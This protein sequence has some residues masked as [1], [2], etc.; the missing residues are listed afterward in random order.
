MN[1]EYITYTFIWPSYRLKNF[2]RDLGVLEVQSLFSNE[3]SSHR[4]SL[5]ARSPKSVP[6]ETLRN[7]A[8]FRKVIVS[9]KNGDSVEVKPDQTLLERSVPLVRMG[10]TDR[11]IDKLLAEINNIPIK[12]RE[13]QY[14][15][16]RL[17]P[18]KGRYYPQLI[19]PLLN[20]TAKQGDV[21][22]DPF[23]GCGTTLLECYFSQMSSIGVDLNPIAFFISKVKMKCA[24]MDISRLRETVERLLKKCNKDVAIFRTSHGDKTLDQFIQN[25]I[26]QTDQTR[27]NIP[28]IPNIHKWFSEGVVEELMIILDDI[29]QIEDEDAKDFCALALSSIVKRVSNWDPEQ[30]RQGLLKKP[31]ENVLVFET[32]ERQLKKYY[33]IVYTYSKIR[34]KLHIEPE[35]FSEV[36]LHDSRHMEFIDDESIDAIVTSPPYATALPYIDTDRLP[37]VVLGLMKYRSKEKLKKLMIGER[38]IT[39]KDRDQLELEFLSQYDDLSLPLVAKE[40]IRKILEANKREKVGFR[41]KNKASILYRYFKGMGECLLEMERV[42]KKGGYCSIIIGNNRTKAGGTEMVRIQTHEI[43]AEMAKSIGFKHI[44]TIPM[45]PTSPYMIH[46]NNRIKDEYVLIFQL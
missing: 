38:D 20:A 9:L 19:K 16:H 5:V 6:I 36:Y 2:E 46:V 35:C 32:F 33:L 41:R 45:A 12:R 13:K 14:L 7:L 43:L 42:L 25:N 23:C 4:G 18:Y 11:D 27:K 24:K 37:M 17:H 3:V 40:T 44:K 8:S 30:V 29:M 28:H 15:M 10:K 26:L 21:V 22:L 39:P 31:R 34:A 1:T